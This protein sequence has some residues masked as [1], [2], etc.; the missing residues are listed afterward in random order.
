MMRH[1]WAFIG[2][3]LFVFVGGMIIWETPVSNSVNASVQ[4]AG[5]FGALAVA[6]GIP[7]VNTV[8]MAK[9][10]REGRVSRIL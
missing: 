8:Y 5:R 4:S 7:I 1:R 6:V 3:T 9:R 10:W 2:A